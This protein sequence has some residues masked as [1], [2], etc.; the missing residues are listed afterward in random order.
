MSTPNK[1]YVGAA[2]YFER[3]PDNEWLEDADATPPGENAERLRS[4][5]RP[6]P[7]VQR[8]DGE[9]EGTKRAPASFARP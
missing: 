6:C 2:I 3:M 5:P 7:G 1:T 8:G 9:K 4:G